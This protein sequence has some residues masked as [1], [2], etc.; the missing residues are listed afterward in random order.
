V[1]SSF[2]ICHLI[3]ITQSKRDNLSMELVTTDKQSIGGEAKITADEDTNKGA[4]A[5]HNF[6]A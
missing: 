4:K 6:H 1:P 3:V 2:S 5:W